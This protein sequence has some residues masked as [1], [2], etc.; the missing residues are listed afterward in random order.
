MFSKTR[1]ARH[2]MAALLLPI[3]QQ[4]F[5]KEIFPC[6]ASGLQADKHLPAIT[7]YFDDLLIESDLARKK[8]EGTFNIEIIARDSFEI[9]DLLDAIAEQVE[10]LI[11]DANLPFSYCEIQSASYRPDPDTA[12]GTLVLTYDIKL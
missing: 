2:Q 4:G 8:V 9:D 5:V 12:L 3:Q 10:P 11:D 6:K 7:M 1:Y